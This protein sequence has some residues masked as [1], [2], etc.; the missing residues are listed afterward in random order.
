[1]LSSW[2]MY[3]MHPALF[4]KTGC[5]TAPAVAATNLMVVAVAVAMDP[6]VVVVE[7]S[8]PSARS[9]PEG[10]PPWSHQLCSDA[11]GGSPNQGAD[12]RRKTH[13]SGAVSVASSP[14]AS[15]RHPERK[16]CSQAPCPCLRSWGP[17]CNTQKLF[18]RNK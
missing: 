7:G 16:S 1:M 13:R 15:Q 11:Y 18:T 14:P 2:R 3:E 4:L 10:R 8:R 5:D 12:P 6:K 17:R 9:R